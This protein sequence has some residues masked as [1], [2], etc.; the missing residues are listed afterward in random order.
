MRLIHILV[1]LAP[2]AGGCSNYT[3]TADAGA[4]IAPD[5]VRGVAVATVQAPAH[6]GVDYGGVTASLADEL[7]ACSGRPARW[8]APSPGHA[9]VT[10]RS[11]FIRG[12][13]HGRALRVDVTATCDASL[14]ART[15]SASANSTA[16]AQA[17]DQGQAATRRQLVTLALTRAS[18]DAACQAILSLWTS[19]TPSPQ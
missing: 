14:G 4:S 8:G 19:A 5:D 17:P 13:V 16:G 6:E 2:L 10:C 18:R 11:E 3:W 12:D 1:A 15:A 9:A 7:S